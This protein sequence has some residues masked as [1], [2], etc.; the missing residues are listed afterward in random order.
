MQFQKYGFPV[1]AGVEPL[2]PSFEIILMFEK[3]TAGEV[4][5]KLRFSFCLTESIFFV[6]YFVNYR[7]W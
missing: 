6:Y 5:F 2:P 4:S 1:G 3:S 7:G